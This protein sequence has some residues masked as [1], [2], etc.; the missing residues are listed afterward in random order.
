MIMVHHICI[1]NKHL[2]LQL[3]RSTSFYFNIL[4]VLEIRAVMRTTLNLQQKQHLFT[5]YG[6]QIS[7]TD[8]I[9]IFFVISK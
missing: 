4:S 8:E 9:A 7:S 6:P 5:D 3:H 1:K 2:F